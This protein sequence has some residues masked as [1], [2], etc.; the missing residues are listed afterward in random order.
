MVEEGFA[1]ADD[2]ARLWFAVEG[3]GTPLVL[4]HGGPGLWDYLQPLARPLRGTARVI[5][6]EQRG[7]GRSELRGPYSVE[8]SVADLDQL[9]AHLGF[10]SWIVGGHSW[11]ATLAL[12]YALAQPARVAALVYISGVGLGR[13]WSAVYHEQADLRLSDE[14]R[15]RRDELD[16]LDRTPAEEREYRT[17]CWAPDYADPSDAFV[18]AAAEAA[19][20]FPG[21]YECNEVLNAESKTWDEDD[22]IARCRQLDVPALIVHGAEDPRPAW[23]VDSLVAALPRGDLRIIPHAGHLPWVEEPIEVVGAVGNFARNHAHS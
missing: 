6:W 21:N 16:L 7:C 19:S 4:C 11:G 8:R 12:Q 23:A 5:R 9:R 14:Q 20:P 10:D 22:L 18:L 2:G 15:L 13:A 1:V 3:S 17:L